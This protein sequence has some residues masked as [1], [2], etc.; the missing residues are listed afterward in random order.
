[1]EKACLIS[2]YTNGFILVGFR[3]HNR[4][5]IPPQQMLLGVLCKKVT[6][7]E[8]CCTFILTSS[9]CNTQISPVEVPITKE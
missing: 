8:E 2:K 5:S 3:K 4:P 7:T 1:M 9:P 6:G